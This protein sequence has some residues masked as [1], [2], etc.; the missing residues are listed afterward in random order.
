MERKSRLGVAPL[1]KHE[2]REP[3]CSIFFF[4]YS[5][6]MTLPQESRFVWQ[7]HIHFPT[8]Q[9]EE[10]PRK[11]KDVYQLPFKESSYIK[12]LLTSY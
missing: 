6:A 1:P 9:M 11:E 12:L 8:G 5:Y 10:N 3:G 2:L 4:H 7:R